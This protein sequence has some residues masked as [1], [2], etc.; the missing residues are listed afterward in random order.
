LTTT[1]SGARGDVAVTVLVMTYNHAR[2][3]RQALDSALAQRLAAPFEVVISEDCSTDGTRTIVEEYAA[4]QPERVRLLLSETN[5]G[6]NQVVA[7]GFRAA[8]GRYV[9]MLDGDDYWTVDDKLQAQFDFLESRREFTICFGNA[10][11]V[12]ENS[13][14]LGRLWN[15]PDQPHTTGLAD[16]LRGNFLASCSVM[17]RRGAVPAIPPWYEPFLLTDWPLHVLYAEHGRIGYLDRVLS[18]YRLHD[19]A[20]FS[21]LTPLEKLQSNAEFYARMRRGLGDR[22]DAE[23]RDGQL[24][25][26]LGW[27]HEYVRRG[28]WATAW[29]CLRWAWPGRPYRHPR[30]LAR[31]LA[32]G[33]GSAR[34][35]RRRRARAT[36]AEA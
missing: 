31:L 22:L 20:T 26:F 18:A 7:R 1:T 13:E 6:S 17:Y 3:I 27:A 15:A 19:G 8:R 28:D 35:R 23:L 10:V 29:R 30:S 25:Y 16:I 34:D 4:R 11:L 21:P 2:Y 36:G 33:A 12:D 9:A 14:S 32:V 5:L 24:D